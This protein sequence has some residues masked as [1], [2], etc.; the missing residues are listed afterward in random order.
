MRYEG[1]KVWSLDNEEGDEK[2]KRIL[3]PRDEFEEEAGEGPGSQQE[4]AEAD[5]RELKARMGRRIARPRAIWLS[6]AAAM[7]ILLVGSACW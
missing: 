6:A 3:I 5:L 2:D 4:E 1:F 7:V